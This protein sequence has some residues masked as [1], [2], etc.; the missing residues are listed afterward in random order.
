MK[1]YS[2]RSAI[3]HKMVSIRP[4]NH[5]EALKKG[6]SGGYNNI[7]SSAKIREERFLLR[8]LLLT[9]VF[10]SLTYSLPSRF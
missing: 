8:S 4:V 3:T 7:K 2:P 5:S 10:T 9:G 1:K 6:N